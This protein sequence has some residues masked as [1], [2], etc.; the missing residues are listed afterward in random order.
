MHIYE[1]WCI[2]ESTSVLYIKT[3]TIQI[4]LKFTSFFK[5]DSNIEKKNKHNKNVNVRTSDTY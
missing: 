5:V 2:Y 1:P 3:K 4:V